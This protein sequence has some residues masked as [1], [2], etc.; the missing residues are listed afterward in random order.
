MEENINNNSLLVNGSFNICQDVIE[1]A[2]EEEKK[3]KIIPKN[4]VSTSNFSEH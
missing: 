4:Y 2:Q 1:E 3:N